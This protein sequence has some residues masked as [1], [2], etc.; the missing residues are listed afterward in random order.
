MD[1]DS[2]TELILNEQYSAA[3]N[4]TLSDWYVFKAPNAGDYTY[5]IHNIDVDCDIYFAKYAPNSGGE[6]SHIVNEDNLGILFISSFRKEFQLLSS[7]IKQ[8]YLPISQNSTSQNKLQCFTV[9]LT[10]K[11]ILI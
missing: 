7:L 10:V 2:A 3:I 9:N 1:K 6:G 8:K 11:L 5:T 4:S